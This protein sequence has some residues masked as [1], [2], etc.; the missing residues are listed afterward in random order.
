[1]RDIVASLL[2]FDD[3]NRFIDEISKLDETVAL[4]DLSSGAITA[5]R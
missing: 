4:R 3:A 2:Q 5:A 1:M